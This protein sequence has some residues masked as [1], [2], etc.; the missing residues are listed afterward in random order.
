[1]ISD[2]VSLPATNSAMMLLFIY[3]KIAIAKP[4]SLSTTASSTDSQ[5]ALT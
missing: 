2:G 3:P 5:T 1:M 4:C